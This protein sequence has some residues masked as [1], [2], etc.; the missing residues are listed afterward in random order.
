MKKKRKNLK[1]IDFLSKYWVIFLIIVA[2]VGCVF[3][4][5]S[6]YKEEVLNIDPDI[7]YE[8]QNTLYFAVEKITDFDPY[9][10][11]S[12]D[13]YYLSNILYS[14][15]FK[16]DDNMMAVPD[17]VEEYNVKTKDAY[18]DFTIREDAK[19]SNGNTITASDVVNCII[20]S[21]RQGTRSPYYNQVKKIYSCYQRNGRVYLYFKNNYNCSTDDLV[22][23]IINT[24]NPKVGSGRY[25]ISKTTDKESIT[26]KPNKYYFGELATK[27]II[28]TILPNRS[29][30]KSMM[31]INEVT[32]YTDDSLDRKSSA[33][34]NKYKIYDFPSNNV[35]FMIF[36]TN[37]PNIKK[38]KVRKALLTAIDRNEILSDAYMDDGVLTDTVYYPNFIGVTEELNYY[39]YSPEIALSSLKVQGFNDRSED[40]NLKDAIG[41]DFDITILTN[42]SNHMRV[43][44]ARMIKKDFE[45]LGIRTNIVEVKDSEFKNEIMKM[46]YDILI[47]GYSINQ[48]YDLRFLFDGSNE[49]GFYDYN[50][51]K[52]ARELDRIH[53]K[54][55][56]IEK[57][58]ELKKD[59]IDSA[60]YYPL[61]YR[62]MSLIGLETFEAGEL[63][64]FNNPYK[65]LETWSWK[66]ILK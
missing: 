48:N 24:S 30:G 40:G 37:R 3:S 63:P 39:E 61:C 10:T 5:L 11:M 56:Y 59:L 57:Y 45:A 19:F 15:L 25:Y 54:E 6:V 33:I 28:L 8:D 41:N 4:G 36:N 17:L 44:A 31:D 55:K 38:L 2:I 13:V 46:D 14:Y 58:T 47:T 27:K 35:D 65:N 34:N 42:Q 60:Q 7:E 23:P 43:Q 29:L 18:I 53:S 22:I 20:Y 9:N 49:W 26:L 64:M 51:L 52:E 12:E 32:C 62:Y 21:M 1:F 66:K 50:L 16:Y